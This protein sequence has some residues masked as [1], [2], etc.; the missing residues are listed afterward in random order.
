MSDKIFKLQEIFKT[1]D[2]NN[3]LAVEFQAEGGALV[4]GPF[5]SFILLVEDIGPIRA[6]VHVNA[7]APNMLYIFNKFSE[8]EEL[9]IVYDG[10]FA[11]NGETGD[12]IIG[13]DAYTKKE[14]NILM[15]AQDIM[16]RRQAPKKEEGLYVPEKKIILA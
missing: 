12:L 8:A 2:P 3:E 13:N 9:E 14:E 10:P 4:Y 16:Q 11:V 1:I 6:L 7:D 5:P 15:F